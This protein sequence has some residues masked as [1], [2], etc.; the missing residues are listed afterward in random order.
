MTKIKTI[1]IDMDGVIA[2]FVERF[3]ELSPL[4]IAELNKLPK[5]EK[6]AAKME[7]I[8]AGLFATMP[9]MP[10]AAELYEGL[11]KLEHEKGI[12]LKILT[13]VG[14]NNSEMVAEEKEEWVRRLFCREIEFCHVVKS[15]SKADYATEE[16]ILI[17]DRTKS[18]EPFLA[19][20]GKVVLHTS[21]K[22]TLEAIS[23][24]I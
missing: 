23:K 4:T 16:T 14:S 18:T 21:A 5:E 20:G 15:H 10:D 22:T 12:T 7:A 3:E 9:L 17:D 8:E 2:S 1:Y 11:L 13:A 6:E 24:M 19:A